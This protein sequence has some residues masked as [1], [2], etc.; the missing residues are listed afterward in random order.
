MSTAPEDVALEPA[1]ATNFIL[2]KNSPSREAITSGPIE[3]RALFGRTSRTPWRI[4]DHLG[5][6]GR[7]AGAGHQ[8]NQT[9]QYQD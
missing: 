4:L 8:S 3:C 5:R 1:K 7:T 2:L 9:R 6:D